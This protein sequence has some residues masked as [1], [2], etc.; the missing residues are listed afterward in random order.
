MIEQSDLLIEYSLD[1]GGTWH[2]GKTVPGWVRG[3]LAAMSL[4]R[5][6]VRQLARHDH[7]DVERITTRVLPEHDPRAVVNQLAQAGQYP[8]HAAVTVTRLQLVQVLRD[9]A[10]TVTGTGVGDRV[11]A[12]LVKRAAA[13][14]P[15]G[16]CAGTGKIVQLY[17]DSPP[18][19]WRPGSYAEGVVR[20]CACPAGC[21]S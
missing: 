11:F 4:Q 3:D 16:R 10:L 2:H 18:E 1:G 12:A 20:V 5:A 17:P 21:P 9:E 8:D 6:A 13:D 7:G 19:P 15:C 14:A